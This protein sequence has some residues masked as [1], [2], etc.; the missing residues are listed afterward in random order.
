MANKNKTI[1]VRLG[2]FEE[3]KLAQ[4]KEASGFSKG[5][6]KSNSKGKKKPNTSDYMRWLIRHGEKPIPRDH[7]AELIKVNINLIKLGGLFNQYIRL[8][9]IERNNMNANGFVDKNNPHF[10]KKSEAFEQIILE[11]SDDLK[12]MKSIMHETLKLEGV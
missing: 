4:D 2:A 7:Y 10:L 8:S 1:T 6:D 5:R 12:L 9:H 3:Q 11:V